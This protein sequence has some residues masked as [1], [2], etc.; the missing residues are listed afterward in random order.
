[1][2]KNGMA[3]SGAFIFQRSVREKSGHEKIARKEH[4]YRKNIPK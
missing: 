4:N 3:K 2:N 1:M